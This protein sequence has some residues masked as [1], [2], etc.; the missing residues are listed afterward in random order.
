MIKYLMTVESN[1]LTLDYFK[2][3]LLTKKQL[4]YNDN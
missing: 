1:I 2:E 3:I 4:H